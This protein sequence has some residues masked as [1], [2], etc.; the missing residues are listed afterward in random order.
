M[1]KHFP[2][3]YYGIMWYPTNITLNGEIYLGRH[4]MIMMTTDS[5]WVKRKQILGSPSMYCL[6]QC[7]KTATDKKS[8]PRYTFLDVYQGRMKTQITSQVEVNCYTAKFSA[9]ILDFF[10]NVVGKIQV[11]V[12]TALGVGLYSYA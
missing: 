2:I 3:D 9:D 4:H 6:Q 8:L 11:E 1:H 5:T 12:D 10:D 7:A